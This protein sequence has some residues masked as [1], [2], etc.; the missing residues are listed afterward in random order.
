MSEEKKYTN[1]ILT[2]LYET[3]GGHFKSLPLDAKSFDKFQEVLQMGG[4]L[5]IRRRTEEARSNAK[6]P[7]T[8]PHAFLEFTAAEDVKAYQE[9]NPRPRG[10]TPK[11]FNNRKGL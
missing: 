3:K 6:N 2:G 7:D 5:F 1:V 8:T 4:Q 9:A 10:N 11:N